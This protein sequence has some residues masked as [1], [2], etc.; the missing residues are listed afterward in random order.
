MRTRMA[1]KASGLIVA[2]ALIVA[3]LGSLLGSC[4]DSQEESATTALTEASTAATGA[5]ESST[6]TKI[7]IVTPEV[8]ND[9]G[10]NQM[11]RMAAE[12]IGQDLNCPVMVKDGSGYGDVSPILTQLAD[13]GVD[14]LIA[15]ASGYN[16]VAPIVAEKYQIPTVVM[17]NEEAMLPGLIQNVDRKAW[18]AAY[19]AG[20]VAA[21]TTLTKKIAILIS[22]DNE[23]WNQMSGAFAAAVHALDPSVELTLAQVGPAAYADAAAAKRTAEATIA[24]GADIVFG[25]GDGA[26]FGYMQACES[27][28]PPE[29]AE[30]VWFIDVIGDKSS[31]DTED[32]L[33]TSVLNKWNVG[34]GLCADA[35]NGGTFGK[36]TVFLT[37]SNGGVDILKTEHIPEDVWE[38]VEETR[39]R[40]SSGDLVVPIT[41]TKPELDA[42]VHGE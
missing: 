22:A 38:L 14:F 21:K 2:L 24:G 35:L 31:I 8:A 32:I 5:V 25:M 30:K 37:L 39:T 41:S 4:G 33:L 27:A 10:F 36:E 42:I 17:M 20:V 19:L 34:Y 40:I 28:A 29:G 7:A 18:D 16:T 12:Q 15:H 9:F 3:I 23:N 11:G 26:S 6:I 13:T 1:P